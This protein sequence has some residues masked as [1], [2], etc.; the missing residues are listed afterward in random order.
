M[1]IK[2]PILTH[3]GKQVLYDGT[4]FAD[5]ATE[6]GAEQI[7]AGVTAHLSAEPMPML[8]FGEA[9]AVGRRLHDHWAKM[10]TDEPPMLPDDLGWADLVQLVAREARGLVRARREKIDG[11]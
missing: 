8:T 4:H 2:P 10:T 5:A 7:V 6:F 1:T 9:E 3:T 11:C